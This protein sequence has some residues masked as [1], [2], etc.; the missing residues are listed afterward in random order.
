M[1]ITCAHLACLVSSLPMEI[2]TL[3]LPGGPLLGGAPP[4]LC[5]L[6]GA[7]QVMRSWVDTPV[8]SLVDIFPTS[9][10]PEHLFIL[11]IE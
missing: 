6:V 1:P 10:H 5:F 8:L 2:F 11:F 4:G 7:G 3:L 9:F